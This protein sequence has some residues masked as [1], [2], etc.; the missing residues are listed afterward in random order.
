MYEYTKEYEIELIDKESAYHDATVTVWYMAWREGGYSKTRC[1]L[2]IEHAGGT[3]RAEFS[4]VYHAFQNARAELE[5][6]GL[7]PLCWGACADV[8]V[9]GMALSMGDG[10]KA[11]R[12]STRSDEASSEVVSIFDTGPEV[13][14]EIVAAQKEYKA[15]MYGIE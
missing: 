4:D 5:Q 10:T 13:H 1:I 2:R 12:M 8:Q 7:L 15:R 3:V 11:Y 6:S 9:S 14:P